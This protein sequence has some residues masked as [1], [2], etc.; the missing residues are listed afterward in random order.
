MRFRVGVGFDSHS[1]FE[2]EGKV[3]I[4]GVPVL[5]GF[6]VVSHSDGD[7]L[8]HAAVDAVLGAASI[9]DIGVLFPDSDQRYSGARSLE[10]LYEVWKMV[11]D[12]GF[13]L[14]NM[15]AVVVS[16]LFLV[17]KFRG[18]I[19]ENLSKVFGV[20]PESIWVKGKRTEGAFSSSSIVSICTV[21]LEAE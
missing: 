4:G 2:G 21:L 9:S 5:E 7:V 12:K 1:V 19:I 11:R 20:D 14:V 18:K 15:D 3:F 8:C 13:S 16:D 6:K 17:S 10:F